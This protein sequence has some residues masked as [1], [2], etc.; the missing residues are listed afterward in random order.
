MAVIKSEHEKVMRCCGITREG[1]RC[2]KQATTEF[3]TRQY[4]TKHHTMLM[5]AADA[6]RKKAAR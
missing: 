3:R 4:C 2:I 5:A 1:K 6:E